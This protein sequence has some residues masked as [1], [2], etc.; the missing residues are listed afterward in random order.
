MKEISDKLMMSYKEAV[1]KG[2]NMKNARLVWLIKS[3]Q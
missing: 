3:I 1:H 2:T